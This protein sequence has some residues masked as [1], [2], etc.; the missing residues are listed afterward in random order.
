MQHPSGDPLEILAQL[1]R[2]YQQKYMELEA[3]LR[4][5]QPEHAID[6]LRARAELTTDRFR[7]AQQALLS[8][9]MRLSMVSED[10]ETLKAAKA[11]CSCFDEM[12]ILF[13]MLLDFSSKAE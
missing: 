6:Q 13:Q 10:T 9:V 4:E 12:R 5:T 7:A 11:L 8:G 3:F 1:A 2:E